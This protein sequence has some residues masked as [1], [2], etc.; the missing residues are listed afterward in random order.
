MIRGDSLRL[1]IR[2]NAVDAIVTDFPY[3]QSTPIAAASPADFYKGALAEMYRVLKPGTPGGRG[4]ERAHGK[5]INRCGLYC[6]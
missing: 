4:I 2:D 3:G 5:A 1:G 6:N